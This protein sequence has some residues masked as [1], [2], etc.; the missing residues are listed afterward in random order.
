M[1]L[2]YS[3]FIRA[4]IYSYTIKSKSNT[5]N[6]GTETTYRIKNKILQCL[7]DLGCGR[8]VDR[9]LYSKKVIP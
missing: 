7:E 9:K 3:N 1:T 2:R 8:F 6:Q 5:Q 4:Y